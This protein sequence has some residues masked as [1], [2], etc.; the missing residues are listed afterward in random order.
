MQSAD[1][2]DCEDYGDQEDT[3]SSDRQDFSKLTNHIR[4]VVYGYLD[5]K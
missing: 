1:W 4:L 2:T 3:K 5:V